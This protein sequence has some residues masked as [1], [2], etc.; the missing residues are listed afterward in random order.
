M[1]C[2]NV[3]VS[4]QYVYGEWFQKVFVD[5]DFG[6]FV[7]E[8]VVMVDCVLNVQVL[9]IYFC[10]ILVNVWLMIGVLLVGI[11]LL[12]QYDYF[13]MLFGV[14]YYLFDMMDF[15]V[16]GMMNENGICGYGYCDMCIYDFG[17]V[18]GECGWGK[19]GVLLM[20]FQM[21]VI[22]FDWF[23]VLFGIWYLK[24]CVWIF[25]LLNMFFDWYGLFDDDY[26]V[27]VEVGKLLWVLCCDCD[28]MLIVG[29]YLVVIDSVCK[30][31]LVWLLLLGCGVWLKLLK[32]GDMVD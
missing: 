32:G 5:V 17:W 26:Q 11:G 3:F 9:F 7:G 23:E 8:Y 29:C 18:D 4:E 19:G 22:D 31:C 24:G 30:I 14:F 16:E 15:C 2:L 12:G 6:D 20:C 10:V 21:Y 28:I 27:C 25:V 13:L 1:C